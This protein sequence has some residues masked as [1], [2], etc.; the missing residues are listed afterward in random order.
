METSSTSEDPILNQSTLLPADSLALTLAE[1]ASGPESR[2][3]IP[4]SGRTSFDWSLNYD[5]V[6]CSWKMSQVCLTG[7]LAEFSGTWPRAGTMQNGV[8][9]RLPS[10]DCPTFGSGC[11]LLPTPGAQGRGVSG[12][13]ACYQLK[14]QIGR[15]FYFE[16][17]VEALMGFPEGW[18][19]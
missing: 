1:S 15:D 17:E 9:F 8:A 5:P 7:D 18:T 13:N 2:P 12:S 11:S 6:S 10:L 16:R 3:S 14:S 19:E 4:G